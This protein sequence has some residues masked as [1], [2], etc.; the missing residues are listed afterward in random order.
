MQHARPPPQD[1]GRGLAAIQP[2][3]GGLDADQAHR[4]VIEEGWKIPI[5]F[6]PPPMAATITSGRRPSA[7]AIW[8]RVSSPI[9]D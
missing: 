2:P 8:T 6:D 5:A 4:R 9:T 3:P 7:S 1:R